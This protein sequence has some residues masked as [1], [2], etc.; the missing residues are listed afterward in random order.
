MSTRK[1]SRDGLASSSLEERERERERERNTITLGVPFQFRHQTTD[2]PVPNGVSEG[3]APKK[4]D[5]NHMHLLQTTGT[6]LC[7]SVVLPGQ[8]S[9]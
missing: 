5:Y 9:L 7:S 2:G 1:K 4:N 3:A 8:D 6:H